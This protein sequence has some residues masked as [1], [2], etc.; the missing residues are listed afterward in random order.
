MRRRDFI[1]LVGGAAAQPI[2]A[3][4]QQSERIRRVGVFMSFAENDPDSRLGSRL[5][6][7]DCAISVGWKG[8]IFG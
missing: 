1:N 3:W 8:A 4:A 5:C 2:A 7:K 6:Y